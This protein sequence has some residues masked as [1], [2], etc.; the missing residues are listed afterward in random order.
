M[1]LFNRSITKSTGLADRCGRDSR[2]IRN[3]NAPQVSFLRT[4]ARDQREEHEQ[5][6]HHAHDR[7]KDQVPNPASSRA[8][9]GAGSAATRSH[10]EARQ[11]FDHTNHALRCESPREDF[12][13][14]PGRKRKRNYQRNGNLYVPHSPERDRIAEAHNGRDAV[15]PVGSGRTPKQIGRPRLQ[16]D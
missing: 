6:E 9:R 15:L 12:R 10:C 2:H 11:P 13:R 8:A 16:D 7:T 14:F 3:E 5:S 4:D 1:F